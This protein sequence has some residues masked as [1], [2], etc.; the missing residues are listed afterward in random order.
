MAPASVFLGSSIKAAYLFLEQVENLVGVNTGSL[1]SSL[2]PASLGPLG[3]GRTVGL[4]LVTLSLVAIWDF[5]LNPQDAS[6][7][8]IANILISSW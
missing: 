4:W 3:E 2:P 7:L 6:S 8:P 1:A 5:A